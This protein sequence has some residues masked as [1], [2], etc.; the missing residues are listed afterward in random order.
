MRVHCSLSPL[1]WNVHSYIYHSLMTMRR[2]EGRVSEIKRPWGD[3]CSYL[4]IFM[5]SMVLPNN[6]RQNHYTG[7]LA[8][9]WLVTMWC[10]MPCH[11]HVHAAG[12]VTPRTCSRGNKPLLLQNCHIS[13]CRHPRAQPIDWIQRKTGFSTSVYQIKGYGPQSSEMVPFCWPHLS[14]VHN[15]CHCALC[16]CAQLSASIV[17]LVKIVELNARDI[18]TSRIRWWGWNLRSPMEPNHNVLQQNIGVSVH[19]FIV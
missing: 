8:T 19:I 6:I 17:W 18:Y 3:N 1:K 15:A 2:E 14:T 9:A 16:S 5:P 12:F 4:V 10:A 11:V 13:R 7:W